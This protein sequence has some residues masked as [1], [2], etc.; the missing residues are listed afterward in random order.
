MA[1]SPYFVRSS[2][3]SFHVGAKADILVPPGLVTVL[4]PSLQIGVK[5]PQLQ[6]DFST[7]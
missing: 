1:E 6:H 5:F 4:Y 2:E 7:V 3:M